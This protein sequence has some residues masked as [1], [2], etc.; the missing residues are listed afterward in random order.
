[1]RSL[2]LLALGLF[3]YLPLVVA[4][5]TSNAH[6]TPT[7]CNTEP[8]ATGTAVA[9]KRVRRGRD[10]N[11][12]AE[13]V[14]NDLWQRDLSRR[15]GVV[16]YDANCNNAPPANSGYQP[17]NGFPTMQSVLQQAYA[18]TVTLADAAANIEANSLA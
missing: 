18:D 2:S 5:R 16:T 7:V 15:S 6:N 14:S 13:T 10:G 12:H 1:M 17:T 8:V 4:D 11:T 9:Q 3:N